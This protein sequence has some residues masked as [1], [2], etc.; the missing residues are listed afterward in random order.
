MDFVARGLTRAL[1]LIEDIHESLPA[2]YRVSRSAIKE[3]RNVNGKYRGRKLS[4][5]VVV[6]KTDYDEPNYHEFWWRERFT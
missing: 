5:S 1:D 6:R 4:V 3:R 2:G